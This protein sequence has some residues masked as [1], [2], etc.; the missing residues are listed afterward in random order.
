MTFLT[1]L[2]RELRASLRA[3]LI[4]GAIFM[5][6]AGINLYDF[7]RYGGANDYRHIDSGIFHGNRVSI[8]KDYVLEIVPILIFVSF[9]LA[10][11]LA[12][13]QFWTHQP[14]RTW[15]FLLHRSV[16]REMI[17]TSKLVAAALVFCLAIG[18][19]WSWLYAYVNHIKTTAF[20]P[21]T[22][23]LWDG[24]IYVVLGYVGYL[25]TALTVL[26]RTRWYTTRLFSWGLV[27]PIATVV[28]A[29]TTLWAAW[30]GLL[31]GTAI[32]MVQLFNTFSQREF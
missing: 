32:L 18:I 22:R 21:P 13:L 24:W 28:I 31:A 4:V 15:G 25:A 3:L 27:I 9:G 30:M 5:I 17:L 10:V 23:I 1:L 11:G 8:V 29:Q 2:K 6:L 14:T 20:P 12:M 19:P 7:V 16:S 26:S